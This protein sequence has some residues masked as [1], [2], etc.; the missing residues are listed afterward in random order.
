MNMD[1]RI[2]DELLDSVNG[3]V[4]KAGNLVFKSTDKSKVKKGNTLYSGQPV[5]AGNLL[6]KEDELPGYE[7]P[8]SSFI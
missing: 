6:Y 1:N 5:K 8:T 3:G 2:D 7:P 4:K